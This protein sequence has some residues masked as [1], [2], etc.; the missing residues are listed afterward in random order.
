MAILNNVPNTDVIGFIGVF[1]LVASI[2]NYNS[3]LAVKYQYKV[4]QF[5]KLDATKTKQRTST[6]DTIESAHVFCGYIH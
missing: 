4:S 1:S 5:V 2:T 3:K 6:I